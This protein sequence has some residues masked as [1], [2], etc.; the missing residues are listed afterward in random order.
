MQVRRKWKEMK[1]AENDRKK[2]GESQQ[3]RKTERE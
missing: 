1:K 3:V 2:L